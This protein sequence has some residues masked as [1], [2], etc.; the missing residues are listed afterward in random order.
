MRFD[1]LDRIVPSVGVECVDGIHAIEAIASAVAALENLHM[2]P[3]LSVD[4]TAERD[5]PEIAY[6]RADLVRNRRSQR[7][8]HR[9]RELIAR[10]KARDN[11]C[12]KDRVGERALRRNDG[13]WPR[14]P[15]VL[16]NVA[17]DGAVEQDRTQRQ[18]HRAIN[19][20]LERQVDRPVGYLRRRAGEVDGDLVAADRD[21]N[22]EFKIA[23]RRIRI[24]LISIDEGLGFIN[25]VR[26]VADGAA[27]H[28]FGIVHQIF[29]AP[30]TVARPYRRTRSR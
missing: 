19:G 10:G 26:N 22:R 6:S 12:R 9:V 25:A 15:V 8:H 3:R 16:G 21:G 29:V 1:V 11:R 13:N 30:V 20:A 18:P 7:L 28:A 23:P 27:H 2:H 4:G 24:V 14:D 5:H 17:V